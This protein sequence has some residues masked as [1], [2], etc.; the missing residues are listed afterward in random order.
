MISRRNSLE[1]ELDTSVRC[2]R[3]CWETNPSFGTNPTCLHGTG[4]PKE[5]CTFLTGKTTGYGKTKIF[6]PNLKL[7]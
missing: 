1:Q 6:H 4:M 7:V 2:H 3:F 5:E